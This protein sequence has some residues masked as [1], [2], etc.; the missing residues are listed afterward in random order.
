[1]KYGVIVESIWHAPTIAELNR[2]RVFAEFLPDLSA[3]LQLQ[4]IPPNILALTPPNFIRSV[5][6]DY[7]NNLKFLPFE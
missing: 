7:S 4:L 6:F 2:Q 3:G 1:M 5:L